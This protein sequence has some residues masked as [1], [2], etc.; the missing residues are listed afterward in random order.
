MGDFLGAGINAT[1]RK[2]IHR[3]TNEEVA[4]KIFDK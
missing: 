3:E 2:A 4:I 1:V